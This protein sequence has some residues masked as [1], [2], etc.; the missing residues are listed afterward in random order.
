MSAPARVLVVDDEPSIREVLT[1]FLTL[2][3]YDVTG[4]PDGESAVQLLGAQSFDAVLLDLKMPGMSGLDVLAHLQRLEPAPLTIMM[5]GY[6]TVET[7]IQAMKRGAWDYILKPFKVPEVI[8][9]LER[10]LAQ[11]RL[12]AEN[13]QLR[14]AVQLYEL[15]Q[16]I[17]ATLELSKICG[18]LIETARREYLPDAVGIWLRDEEG[19]WRGEQR[20]ARADLGL[21]ELEAL[22]APDLGALERLGMSG[23]GFAER[24]FSERGAAAR[25]VLPGFGEGRGLSIVAL[26]LRS[27]GLLLGALLVVALDEGRLLREG[28]RKMLSVL[29]DHASAAIEN[30]RLYREL[31]QTFKQTIQALAN[32]LEDKDPYTRGHSDRVGRYARL[33]AE[34]LG[35]EPARIEEIA[36]SALMHDIGKLGIRYEDLNK[37]EPLTEAEYEMFKSHTTRGKWILE[38]I[39]FLRHLIPGVYHHH[40]RWDGRG[41]PMG[42]RG[43]SIPLEARILAIADTYDAMTSHRAYRRALPHDVAM[44]E[45]QAFAGKQFDPGLVE[46]FV[47]EMSRERGLMRSKSQ[48]WSALKDWGRVGSGP[49]AGQPGMAEAAMM[50]GEE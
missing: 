13:I 45:I 22:G 8:R 35:L 32:L 47:R 38:P 25:A 49:Q 40:E 43:E 24:G 27:K 37:A 20:W 23:V 16:T 21:V 19:A 4:V 29:C 36:D 30:A 14:E 28:T 1:D 10:G 5:T 39:R 46:V 50:F 44:R 33:I 9:L 34:G 18:L 2:D 48:R 12:E 15:S 6:G 7:A 42:L 26:P 3:G 31:Q 11:R 41:Y 17:G